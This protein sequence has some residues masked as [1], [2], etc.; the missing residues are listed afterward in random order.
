MTTLKEFT[1]VVA[2]DLF[3]SLKD[4]DPR[5]QP[6]F[7]ATEDFLGGIFQIPINLPGTAY[8]M[9]C[10]G[11]NTMHAILETLIAE[12]KQVRMLCLCNM[13]FVVDI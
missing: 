1:F 4:D 5:F 13:H 8:R 11:R 2:S 7:N 6:L 9:G 12:R 3:V 10:L